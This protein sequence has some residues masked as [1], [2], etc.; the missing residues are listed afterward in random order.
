M[1]TLFKLTLVAGVVASAF[2]IPAPAEAGLFSGLRGM[3]APQSD[4]SAFEGRFIQPQSQTLG[5][6]VSWQER[7]LQ[8]PTSYA[9]S[10]YQAPSHA[11]SRVQEP[12]VRYYTAEEYYGRKQHQTAPKKFGL[13]Y[14]NVYDYESGRCGSACARPAP[15][16][17]YAPRQTYVP[18]Q[19][20][21]QTYRQVTQYKCWNGQIVSDAGGCP[22][23]TVT[24]T[25]PQFRCWDGEV[26]TDADACKLQPVTR[27]VAVSS[28]NNYISTPSYSSSTETAN[29][30]SGTAKQTDG[31]CLEISSS[32]ITSYD[33]SS[34]YSSSSS[35][36]SG[37][38]YSGS[39][40][41]NCPSGTTAQSDGTCL[42][43]GSS[44]FT[45]SYTSS[46]YAGS[47]VELFSTPAPTTT[48][49]YGYISDGVY[50]STDYP[51]LR[52]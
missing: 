26:V 6:N 34:S 33:S 23:Q 24:E 32:P 37:S 42:E 11:S 10:S 52:K 48:P 38:T 47:S 8:A 28:S 40:P 36:G 31:T 3:F 15:T 44:S 50:G 13:G 21:Q 39:I 16:R 2:N 43:S 45:N 46:P 49:S 41:T 20:Y 19:T 12:G 5:H 35:Y 29:C 22:D 18:R 27:E 4:V 17:T 25:I 30:P 1:N 51:P 7:R 9:Q 14:G